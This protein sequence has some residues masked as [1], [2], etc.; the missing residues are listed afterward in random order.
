MVGFSP[1]PQQ[2]NPSDFNISEAQTHRILIQ[3]H[4]MHLENRDTLL[5]IKE[6]KDRAMQLLLTD[7]FDGAAYQKSID[8]IHALRGQAVQHITDK[9]KKWA[10]NLSKKDRA[11]V[12][13]ILRHPP[14]SDL[15]ID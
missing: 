7:P 6:E 1:H 15:P 2:P 3:L 5:L 8:K 14:P 11:F 10:P 12:A 9:I 13:E 4:T